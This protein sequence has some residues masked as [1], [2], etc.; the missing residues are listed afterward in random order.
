M[1]TPITAAVEAIMIGSGQIILDDIPADLG[2]IKVG[3]GVEIYRDRTD[4]IDD[5]DTRNPGKPSFNI[6]VSSINS[7]LSRVENRIEEMAC[8]VAI[9]KY[10]QT[11]PNTKYMQ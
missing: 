9:V 3:T 6:L 5:Q 4:N 7:N 8:A 11:L 2:Y 10:L 1:K